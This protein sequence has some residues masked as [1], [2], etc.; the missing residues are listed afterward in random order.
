MLKDRFTTLK[1]YNY[2]SNRIALDNGIGQGDLLSMALYQ[3]YNTDLLDI[4]AGV[5][6]AAVAYVD[7]A[8]LITIASD[9]QQTHDILTDMMTRPGRRCS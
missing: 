9:F 5:N 4:P 1:F 3:Y 2:T 7:N 8:I 6:E